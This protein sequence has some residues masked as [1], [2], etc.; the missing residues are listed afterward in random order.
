MP[1]QEDIKAV[2]DFLQAIL[3]ARKNLRIYPSNNP[4]YAK[5]VEMTYQR[6]A[7]MLEYHDEVPLRF[8]RNEIFYG[9]ESVFKGTSKDDNLALFFSR[10]GI[11]DL[12]FKG[13]IAMEEFQDFLE[14]TAYD[15]DKEDV[16]EDVV[17]LMWGKDF[18]NITYTVDET[19]L[20][21]E[22]EEQYEEHAVRQA[23]ERAAGDDDL[24]RAYADALKSEEVAKD[25]QLVPITDADRKTLSAYKESASRDRKGK[26]ID[27]L[28]EIQGQ[29][30]SFYEFHE[31]TTMIANALGYSVKEGDI[32]SAIEVLWRSKALDEKA[33]TGFNPKE[34][35]NLIYRA[36]ESPDN[37]KLI[38][39][40]LDQEP[41]IDD[42]V[43]QEY[44]SF[45]SKDSIPQF[46]TIL[47]ELKSIKA[48]KS[49]VNALVFLGKKDIS[50]LVRGLSDSRW[51]VVRNII[52]ILRR[53]G[54]PKAL[55]YLLRASGHSDPRVRKEML[56][57]LGEIGGQKAAAS[58][59]ECL[60][61]PEPF[62]RT[63][64]ARALGQIG[65]DFA[66]K[67]LIEK[68][69][70][71]NFLNADFNEKKEFFEV[72]T[73]WNDSGVF[74][75]LTRIVKKRVFFKRARYNELKAAAA[76]AL[77]L[78]GNPESLP[79]LEKLRRSGNKF[80]SEYA[81]A[82]MKRIEYGRQG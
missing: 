69:S 23:K 11:K 3:K 37:I 38:G 12:S 28:F 58:I 10:D 36:A 66:K 9:G 7:S 72:L 5:T 40:M 48:R 25:V 62:V 54:D 80:L 34:E 44:V 33:F 39:E 68:M 52:Y 15:L 4:I 59:K 29:A 30:E 73:R 55:G 71:K 42:Q 75:F 35:V 41:G 16:A 81:Y 21:E 57:T 77:G 17:T 20:V 2:R 67:S 6:L 79:A 45:L 53:I 18:H 70:D 32:K 50:T 60:D 14:I 64:A 43:F 49:V 1:D 78:L 26:L 65:S 19:M 61:D 63:T 47:G 56:K 24:Q 46:M 76:N 82:A 27:I 74:D 31:V 51:Y 22:D 8:T 13:G